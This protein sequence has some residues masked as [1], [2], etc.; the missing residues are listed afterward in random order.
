M[1]EQVEDLSQTKVR[2][3]YSKIISKFILKE[4]RT[5]SRITQTQNVEKKLEQLK[6]RIDKLD[7]SFLEEVIAKMAMNCFVDYQQLNSMKNMLKVRIKNLTEEEIQPHLYKYYYD[8]LLKIGKIFK[9]LDEEISIY[10]AINYITKYDPHDH[11]YQ[12]QYH[13][14]EFSK[15]IKINDRETIVRSLKSIQELVSQITGQLKSEAIRKGTM[16]KIFL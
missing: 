13:W 12:L 8:Y 9:V 6:D 10:D 14:I 15:S 11:K 16:M 3:S 1:A 2:H 7:N 5:L 4:C